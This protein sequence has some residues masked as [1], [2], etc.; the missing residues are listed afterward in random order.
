[1]K[2]YDAHWS[3]I[4]DAC[5]TPVSDGQMVYAQFDPHVAV[6]YDLDGN[7]RWIANISDLGLAKRQTADKWVY[8]NQPTNSPVLVGDKL[9]LLNGW[10]RALDKKTGKMIWDTGLL[11]KGFD[12]S[13]DMPHTTCAQSLVPCRIGNADY[14][15]GFHGRLVR[16]SDGKVMAGPTSNVNAHT[17]PVID[18][19]TAYVWSGQRYKMIAN[20]DEVTMRP[21]GRTS[22]SD[23][24]M[25]SPLVYGGLVYY[26]DAIG[27]LRVCDAHTNNL[28]Y[29]Q[30]LDMTPLFHHSS[31]GATASVCL[32]GKHIFLLDDQGA[33]VVIEPGRTFKQVSLNRIDCLMQHPWP[34][35]T[36]ER[37]WSTPTF[38]G[39]C[40]YIRSERNLYCIGEEKGK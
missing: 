25:S 19:D 37:T 14:V 8:P 35:G 29:K 26:L 23:H 9:I 1:M 5:R 38:D 32:A 27:V 13:H 18:G 30:V 40:M 11:E 21:A 10:M 7:R 17:T 22:E 24:A 36:I 28:L 39:K 33:C 4:G 12:K 2:S 15:L 34:I 31:M 16:A 20:G 6:A 3:T